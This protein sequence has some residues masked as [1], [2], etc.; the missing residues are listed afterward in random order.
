MKQVIA[1]LSMLH[2]PRG[3]DSAARRFRDEPVL[4][5]TLGRLARVS[6]LNEVKILCWEDQAEAVQRAIREEG[7][8]T[9]TPAPPLGTGRG[10]RVDCVVGGRREAVA[11]IETVGA[12]RR[13][14]DGW[15]GG[16]LGTCEFDRGFHGAWMLGIARQS[17][18]DAVLLIDPA[19][20]LVDGG[21]IEALLR[22]ARSRPDLDLCF[23]PTA[24]GLNG[25]LLTVGLLEKL[26]AGKSHPGIMLT[27]RPDSPRRDPLGEPACLD[28]PTPLARTTRRFT[29]DSRRQIEAMTAATAHL[30]GE[31]MSAGAME[32][33]AAVEA[34]P[35]RENLPREVVLEINT[36]R[37]TA[38]IFWPGG[39]LAAGRE[40]MELAT[41]RRIFAELAE[42]DDARLVLAG[43]GDPLLHENVIEIIA[44]AQD[45][46]VRAIAIETDFI[47]VTPQRIEALAE[48]AVDI[49]SV[50]L[51]AASAGTYR[52]VMGV[53]G[54]DEVNANLQIFFR[55]RQLHGRGV[56]LLTPTFVKCRQNQAEM[57]AWYDHWIRTVGSAVI[58]G[59]SDYGGLIEDVAAA[60][61]TPPRRRPCVS[62]SRRLMVL[63]DGNVVTCEQDVTAR[64]R[65]GA[66][67]NEAWRAA[68]QLRQDHREQ[69]WD[70]HPACANCR[71]W[72]RG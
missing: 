71:Q 6:G 45:A 14:A 40:P 62:L 46:G 24:P 21:L 15:R 1:I 20:G 39:K 12:A 58:I 61:M 64:Q 28:V 56:P 48:S 26:A 31:L 27:Y 50:H 7:E 23:S 68:E 36:R 44:A 11:E 4:K 43:V 47:G 37:A 2:E 60:D 67:L 66:T 17:G 32:L 38:P 10:G 8:K 51:P 18:A 9:P 57:E 65:L 59:P 29:L 72:H 34:N 49:V 63:A 5:W 69:R 35:G 16:L 42:A 55:R 22:H 3:A 53:G 13:W 54:L 52:A 19:A 33:L 41:A 25:V 70:K 30:N